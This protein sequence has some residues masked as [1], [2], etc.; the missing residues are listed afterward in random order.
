MVDI[1]H[2]GFV[3]NHGMC[4]TKSELYKTMDFGWLYQCRFIDCDKCTTLVGNFDDGKG[5]AYVKAE[6]I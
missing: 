2:Y 1:C 3:Q 6:S 5:Y 4:N